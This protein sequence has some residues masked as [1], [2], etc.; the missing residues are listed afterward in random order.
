MNVMS[1]RCRLPTFFC[2]FFAV[3]CLSVILVYHGLSDFSRFY[4]SGTDIPWD[5]PP[6]V[7]ELNGSRR[8]ISSLNKPAKWSKVPAEAG[9]KTTDAGELKFGDQGSFDNATAVLLANHTGTDSRTTLLRTATTNATS[10][11]A[12]KSHFFLQ[13]Q[14]AKLKE[15]PLSSQVKVNSFSKFTIHTGS[16]YFSTLPQ[17]ILDYAKWHNEMRN[18]FPGLSLFNDPEAPKI[19]IR[20]CDG[21]RCGGTHDRLGQL[22]WDLYLANQTKRVLLISWCHPTPL[23]SFLVPNLLDWTIPHDFDGFHKGSK[24][25]S[26][27]ICSLCRHWN[28][29]LR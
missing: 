25:C 3:I 22:P 2:S 11:S 1:Y 4:D 20:S 23:E 15:K 18:K 6:S 8:E 16:D 14:T 12:K 17:W 9:N 27:S 10:F 19:L 29:K 5:H 21:G 26:Q 28:R 7:E 13:N 24:K